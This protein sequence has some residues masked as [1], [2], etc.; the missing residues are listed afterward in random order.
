[1]AP[2]VSLVLTLHR[3][4]P[5][6]RRT[7]ESL[8]EAAVYAARLGITT[9]LVA[10]LDRADTD[11]HAALARFAGP[12]FAQ[13]RT[14]EVDNGSLGPSR[15]DGVAVASG[16]YVAMCD[17]DDLVSFNAIADAARHADAADPWTLHF[18]E[19]LFG[20]GA[21]SFTTRYFGL[22][23]VT[24]LSFLQLHP[25]TSRAF[26]RREVF[27]AMPYR[28]LR[29]SDGY[30]FE[31]WDFNAAC[32]ARGC[33]IRVVP[34]TALFYRQRAQSLLRQASALSVQQIPPNPLFRPETF[35]RLGAEALRR[36]E[37]APE[38]FTEAGHRPRRAVLDRP[39]LRL[40]IQAANAI[41]PEVDIGRLAASRRLHTNVSERAI[42]AGRA[43]AEACRALQGKGP[44]D[45][46]FLLP[47]A[48][49]GGAETYLAN[50]MTAFHE[51]LPGR[52][53]LA[54]LG[55]PPAV[56]ETRRALPPEVAAFDLG[57]AWPDMP[58]ADRLVVALRI[59]EA[60][61]PGARLHLRDSDFA[62][63]FFR[64]Y[65]PVLNGHAAVFYRF[66][67]G[68]LRMGSDV[69]ATADSFA[70]I[71]EHIGRLDLVV[72]DTE[73]LARQD[74]AR[75]GLWPERI[76]T[77]HGRCAPRTTP[78]AIHARP[79]HGSGR[80][81]WAS[82]LDPE[83]RPE[84]LPRIARVLAERDPSL[85]IDMFGRAVLTEFDT[86]QLQGLPNLAWHGGYDGFA[87]LDTAAYD[88][89]VYTSWYDGMPNV[90]LEAIA[91][92]LPVIAPDVGGIGELVADG[93]SG[94]LL[95]PLADD[96]AAAAAYAEA[97]L[98]LCRDGALRRRLALGALG[99]LEAR[100]VPTMHT[101]RVA[102]LFAPVGGQPAVPQSGT[103]P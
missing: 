55:Q 3:E 38:A 83:K 14:I 16:R 91:A 13:R 76:A 90:V 31:D 86:A 53:I 21:L 6:V 65:W 75:I 41:D 28:D 39:V 17:G 77:L 72:V 93:E 103:A 30:A 27:R 69:F 98:R 81:L 26:A 11:T 57:T 8:H 1:M 59:I 34:D 82:R 29:L 95:P 79:D 85:R 92:G 54:L 94:I 50:V 33:D 84:L 63:A 20:F 37:V 35:L 40:L 18:P 88:G 66:S 4:G 15:N 78:A 102:A 7:L 58:M 9:E 101:A 32:V 5:L 46:V 52:R 70:F 89:F 73:A 96:V 2:D 19:W 25:Y 68:R 24:P 60:F 36:T 42:A 47:F 80:L 87:A 74:R 64:T 97:I 71:S 62:T 56:A 44:F 12:G 45:E 61:A 100:H 22:D 49:T 48:G 99:R 43:Y 10:V 51:T 67:D 23:R